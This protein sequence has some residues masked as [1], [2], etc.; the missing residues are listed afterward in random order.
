MSKYLL[1]RDQWQ[2]ISQ[3]F[4]CAS[5]VP[6]RNTSGRTPSDIRKLSCFSAVTPETF[7]FIIA[8]YATLNT[9]HRLSDW[10]F[11]WTLINLS[12]CERLWTFA[13]Q[14]S[15]YV[16]TD[17]WTFTNSTFC[18]HSVYCAVRT[19]YLCVLCGSENKQR[20]FPYRAL[21]DWFYNWDG[22]CLLRGTSWTYITPGILHLYRVKLIVNKV[23]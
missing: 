16:P 19:E 2:H 13:A 18:P 12:K 14:R 4:W 10:L 23:T 3:Q 15:L 8:I 6:S 21:T 9:L 20:L 11:V 5:D 7:T 22:V 1:S 17:S